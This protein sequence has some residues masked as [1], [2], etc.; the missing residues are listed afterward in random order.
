M[1]LINSLANSMAF[2]DDIIL[3]SVSH[4]QFKNILYS[5]RRHDKKYQDINK[6]AKNASFLIIKKNEHAK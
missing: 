2:G 1:D 6:E 3:I 5:I 4:K